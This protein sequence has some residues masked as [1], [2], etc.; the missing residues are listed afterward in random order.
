VFLH[1]GSVFH[2]FLLRTHRR[3][4]PVVPFEQR[5]CRRRPPPLNELVPR[6][7]LSCRT[8]PGARPDETGNA[9]DR[10]SVQ[11]TA[12]AAAR[13]ATREDKLDGYALSGAGW[14]PSNRNSGNSDFRTDNCE[15]ETNKNQQEN[16]PAQQTANGK[17]RGTVEEET[18]RQKHWQ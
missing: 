8:T 3:R 16:N 6:T 1:A 10:I 9:I 13:S 7:P 18:E 14:C 2:I 15:T 12:R 5:V 11:D 4:R 17:S